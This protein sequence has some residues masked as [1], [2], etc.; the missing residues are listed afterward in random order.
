M[1]NSH[2]I[3]TVNRKVLRFLAKFSDLVGITAELTA[4]SL[5]L[6]DLAAEV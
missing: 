2:I 1:P 3:A 6:A 4:I 5:T